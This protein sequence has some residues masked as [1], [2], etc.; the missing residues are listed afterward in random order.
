MKKNLKTKFLSS[1]VFII[2]GI[3]LLV[4][5]GFSLGKE[6]YRNYQIEK[7]IQALEEEISGLE[8]NND[9]LTH[10]IEYFKTES[11]QEKEARQ[12]LGLQKEGE[13]VVVITEEN[14]E[15]EEF[16]TENTENSIQ[17]FNQSGEI[18][19]E[20]IS[21]PRKWWNFIFTWEES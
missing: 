18:Q 2:I 17:E 15:P 9:N 3:C 21:N 5:I 14:I 16:E 20:E 7:E 11:Y 6:T 12:K 4:F 1:R 19:K 8:K 10:L 13:K